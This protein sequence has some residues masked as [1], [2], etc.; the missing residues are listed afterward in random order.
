MKTS[1]TYNL[2][3]YFPLQFFI[4]GILGLL[5]T[6]PVLWSGQWW[7]ALIIFIPSLAFV[8]MKYATKIDWAKKEVYDLLKLAGFTIKREVFPFASPQH[9]TIKEVTMSQSMGLRGKASVIRS[10]M[11]QGYL[12]T[13]EESHLVLEYKNK[14]KVVR[15]MQQLA[16]E[17]GLELKYEECR[18]VIN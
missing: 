11:Y 12:V 2:E 18:N 5:A 17:M 14:K 6:V 15:L 10:T 1:I 8:T 3:N 7:I 16:R 9:L 4:V 13:E